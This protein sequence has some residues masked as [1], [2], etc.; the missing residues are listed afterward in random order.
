MSTETVL[1]TQLQL[2][3]YILKSQIIETTGYT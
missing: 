3:V 2:H 1:L